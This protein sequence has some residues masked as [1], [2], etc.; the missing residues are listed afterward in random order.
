[1]AFQASLFDS[2]PYEKQ[3]DELLGAIDSL[4]RSKAYFGLMLSAYKKQHL[5]EIEKIMNNPEFGMEE[6]QDILLDKRNRN[7]VVQ[8]K[9]VMKKEPVFVAVGAGHL[10]GKAGLIAL[11]RAE[12]YTV[13]G[14]EN[15]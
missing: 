13:R 6:N 3:A 2:I 5:G 9:Q 7:W 4:E 14:L 12:G 8:L 15:K 11:L 1:M 10:I